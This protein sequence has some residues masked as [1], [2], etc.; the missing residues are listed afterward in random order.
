MGALWFETNRMTIREA[1][2]AAF[3]DIACHG[4]TSSQRDTWFAPLVLAYQVAAESRAMSVP[5][6]HPCCARNLDACGTRHYQRTMLI[7]VRDMAWQAIMQYNNEKAR[8]IELP[9]DM[10]R[11]IMGH[12]S[13]TDKMAW[14]HADPLVWRVFPPPR[15]SC[16]WRKLVEQYHVD[17]DVISMLIPL[18]QPTHDDDLVHFKRMWMDPGV[19]HRSMGSNSALREIMG[20]GGATRVYRYLIL[21]GYMSPQERY[22][23]FTFWNNEMVN[24]ATAH[25]RMPFI[26]TTLAWSPDELFNYLRDWTR[27][28]VYN[29][30]RTRH[31]VVLM[32]KNRHFD[33]VA[34]FVNLCKERNKEVSDLIL[35][36]CCAYGDLDTLAQFPERCTVVMIHYTLNAGTSAAG[37]CWLQTHRPDLFLKSKAFKKNKERVLLSMATK[38]AAPAVLAWLLEFGYLDMTRDGRHI[39]EHAKQ[40]MYTRTLHWLKDVYTRETPREEWPAWLVF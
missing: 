39:Y 37:L 6:Q 29:E 26:H 10:L 19:S 15:P 36:A 11:L 14:R 40:N 27:R 20:M 35:Q 8:L 18:C 4:L 30:K 31:P 17:K 7:V 23:Q 21:K 22:G 32:A 2:D 5:V 33:Q 25:G 38:R 12:L 3:T 13:W 9:N 28:L 34:W 24:A 16:N 1:T